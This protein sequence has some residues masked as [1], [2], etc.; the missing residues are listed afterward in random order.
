NF[1]R[2]FVPELEQLDGE[3]GLDV[4]VSGTVGHPVLSG[5]G[6]MTIN[7]ARFTNVTLPALRGFTARFAFRENALT[8]DRFGGD[9]AGGPF[10]MTGRVTFPK[11]IEPT[12]ALQLNAQSVLFWSNAS[13]YASVHTV[14]TDPREI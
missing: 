1:V 3:L 6:D 12:L 5:A 2:Q 10:T 13:L 9:V 8:L 14:H 4:D 7:V 11:L